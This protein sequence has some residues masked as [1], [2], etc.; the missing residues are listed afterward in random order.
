M[1]IPQ[2]KNVRQLV[3]HVQYEYNK[4][5][6][7]EL[8]CD[9]TEGDRNSIVSQECRIDVTRLEQRVYSGLWTF[10][11]ITVKLILKK[12]HVFAPMGQK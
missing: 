2:N 4:A 7:C 3:W 12:Y 1:M 9:N 6:G 10:W 8:Y 11:G 5:E